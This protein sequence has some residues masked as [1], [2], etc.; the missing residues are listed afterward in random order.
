[1]RLFKRLGAVGVALTAGLPFASCASNPEVELVLVDGCIGSAPAEGTDCARAPCDGGRSF[2]EAAAYAE[3][4]VFNGG[5]PPD[6]DLI[7]GDTSKATYHAVV[8]ASAPLPQIGDLSKD[9]YGFA[10]LL[11]D[12]DCGV[13]AMGCTSADLTNVRRINVSV[14]AWST[15]AHPHGNVCQPYAPQPGCADPLVCEAGRCVGEAGSTDGGGEGDCDLSVV[16]SG[17]LPETPSPDAQVSGPAIAATDGGFVLA[18]RQFDPSTGKLQ[19]VA[20]PLPDG[21]P[22]GKA[23]AMGLASCSSMPAPTDGLGLAFS[24]AEGQV[25]SALQN[26]PSDDGGAGAGAGAAFVRIAPTGA[27]QAPNSLRNPAFTELRL[28][29]GHSLSA[30]PDTGFDLA[31]RAVNSGTAIV[32]LGKLENNG[33]SGSP[34]SV[35]SDPADYGMVATTDKLQAVLGRVSARGAD[36]LLVTDTSGAPPMDAGSDAGDAGAAG[37]AEFLLPD[38]P[39]G[40]LAAAGG[41]VAAVV[42]GSGAG[43]TLLVADAS[44]AELGKSTIT[45]GVFTSGDVAFAHDRLIVATAASSRLTFYRIDGAATLPAVSATGATQVQ[46]KD[47]LGKAS[48]S[49]FDGNRVAIATARGRVAV[50]WLSTLALTEGVPT[51]GWALLSCK[52]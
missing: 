43:L 6:D 25:V 40:A 11:R 35:F 18:Y 34:V 22:L 7:A 36:V 19:V 9:V 4:A 26:C 3:V 32:Q 23:A 45:G 52:K 51:G 39:W 47:T 2:R 46:F 21:G 37:P 27:M 50:V 42:P 38:S 28:A 8:E 24:G 13:L 1:M 48:L 31:F 20:I 10:V 41:R 33:F 30:R 29:Q 15:T 49:D 12:S 44:G 16:A 17:P 14:R 5:C